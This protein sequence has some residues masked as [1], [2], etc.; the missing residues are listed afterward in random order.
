MGAPS[1]L[2]VRGARGPFVLSLLR[3][4]PDHSWLYG[5]LPMNTAVF[6]W[7]I[8]EAGLEGRA[9]SMEANA[10]CYRGMWSGQE[11]RDTHGEDLLDRK[12]GLTGPAAKVTFPSRWWPPEGK[13]IP[14]PFIPASRLT[15]EPTGVWHGMMR[16]AGRKPGMAR[17]AFKIRCEAPGSWHRRPQLARCTGAA[18]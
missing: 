10:T 18:E 14:R 16:L 3:E 2:H 7:R 6:D 8:A 5:R 17:E 1:V 4:L 11:A 15:E 13:T 12:R 9:L